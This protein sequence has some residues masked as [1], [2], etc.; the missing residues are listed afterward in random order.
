MTVAVREKETEQ[1]ST[2][3]KK[4]NEFKEVNGRPPTCYEL[5]DLTTEVEEE[6]KAKQKADGK[7]QPS[8][9]PTSKKNKDPLSSGKSQINIHS[10]PPI[11]FH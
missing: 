5:L 4:V 10:I 8:T 11:A 1:E 2:A 3:I 7:V 6:E 9:N